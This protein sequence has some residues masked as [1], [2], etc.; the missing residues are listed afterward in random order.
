MEE[1]SQ[2]LQKS[3]NF[4]DDDNV[5]QECEN[6]KNGPHVFFR[7][8]KVGDWKIISA[9]RWPEMAR[10]LDEMVEKNQKVRG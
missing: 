2:N 6:H 5:G 7:R 8:E 10:K 1:A 9:M 4:I 3:P